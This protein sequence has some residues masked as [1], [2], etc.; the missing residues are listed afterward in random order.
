MKRSLRGTLVA[1]MLSFAL[2]AVAA[3][4]SAQ[5][6]TGEIFGKVT[7]LTGAVL[8]APPSRFPAMR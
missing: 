8:Q 1:S 5:T 7:D 2:L 6:G 3:A 4:A